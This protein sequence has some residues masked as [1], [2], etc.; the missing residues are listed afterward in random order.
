MLVHFM[1][2][3]IFNVASENTLCVLSDLPKNLIFVLPMCMKKA[4]F[5]ADIKSV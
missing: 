3:C 5:Y 2:I 1:W 4:E